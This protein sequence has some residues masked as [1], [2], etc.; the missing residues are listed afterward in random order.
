MK[1]NTQT[2]IQRAKEVHGDR[3]DYTKVVYERSTKKIVIVCH[4][5]G[6]FFQRP[7]NHV[8]QKQHCPQC[9]NQR[10][11]KHERFS[12]EW[13]IERPERAYAPALLYVADVGEHLEVGVTT[14]SIK[15]RKTNNTVWY[16]RYMSLKEALLLEQKI[17]TELKDYSLDPLGFSRGKTKR[18][19]NL[20]AVKIA[21]EQ[22]LPKN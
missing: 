5:H 14:K 20:P 13:M 19:H 16:L 3:Y 11:G 17:E 10:K 8:N 12:M 9:A 4:V 7:Q 22:I 2:F 6:P 1:L 21:L 18:L 15:Q